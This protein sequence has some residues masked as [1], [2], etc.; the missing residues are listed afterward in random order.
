MF[1][2]SN[3]PFPGTSRIFVKALCFYSRR[4]CGGDVDKKKPHHVMQLRNRPLA[5]ILE[6]SK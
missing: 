4:E 3:G 1:D 2:L 5:N 6:K